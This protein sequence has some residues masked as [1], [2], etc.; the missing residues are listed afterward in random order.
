[1]GIVGSYVGGGI[2][3]SIRA[4][5]TSDGAL[6]GVCVGDTG[7]GVDVGDAVGVWIGCGGMCGRF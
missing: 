1:M 6:V 3:G 7:L 2:G 4:F 5:A